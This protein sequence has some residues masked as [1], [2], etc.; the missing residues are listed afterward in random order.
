LAL[1]SDKF[2]S[3]EDAVSWIM[4]QPDKKDLVRD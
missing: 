2:V 4:A 3:W 1:M